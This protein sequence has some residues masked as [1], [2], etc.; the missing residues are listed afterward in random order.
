MSDHEPHRPLKVTLIIAN[1]RLR[2]VIAKALRAE[3]GIRVLMAAAGPV[4][5]A[6]AW[7]EPPDVVISD[8]APLGHKSKVSS[9]TRLR[10]ASPSYGGQGSGAR[11]EPEA[12]A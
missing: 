6:L 9:R 3:R 8:V 4:E 7:S 1:E 12:E 2:E 11:A 5:A 10:R